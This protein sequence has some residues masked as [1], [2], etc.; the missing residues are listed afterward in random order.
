[1]DSIDAKLSAQQHIP[2]VVEKQKQIHC[3]GG[4]GLDIPSGNK[5]TV[6]N[7]NYVRHD[8]FSCCSSSSRCR[9]YLILHCY[10]ATRNCH[11][12][13]PPVNHAMRRRSSPVSRP[14][15]NTIAEEVSR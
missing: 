6:A 9:Y 3:I 7:P 5:T 12:L 14:T 4:V 15:T 13:V 8:N 2:V 1:M 10:E 11:V